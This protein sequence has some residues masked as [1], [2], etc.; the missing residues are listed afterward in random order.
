MRIL[1]ELRLYLCNYIVNKVPSRR[2]RIFF[3]RKI[4]RFNISS[5]ASIFLGCT[6]D[7]A[8]GLSLGLNSVINT[9]CR[10]DTRGGV[11]IGENVSLSNNCTI[12]TADHDFHSDDFRGRVREVNI[13]D[14][15][16]IGTETMVLPGVRIGYGAI[17]GAKSLVIKNVDPRTFNAGV[18]AKFI[19]E[20][21][22]EFNYSTK[23]SRIFQ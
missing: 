10:I 13:G 8:G 11:N 6:F 16:W 4:M 22:C 19:I 17:V 7:A 3:Y 12:L 18:P 20:R 23:Y 2:F 1:S 21:D 5:G 14:Y 9:N 15:S